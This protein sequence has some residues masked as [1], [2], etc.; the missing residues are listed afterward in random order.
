M[1]SMVECVNIRVDPQCVISTEEKSK[2]AKYAAIRL[3]R[4][5]DA[6][7][8]QDFISMIQRFRDRIPMMLN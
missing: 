6:P 2:R 3:H 1:L 7:N 8:A 5:P 4:R